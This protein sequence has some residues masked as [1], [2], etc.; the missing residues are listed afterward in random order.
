MP[1]LDEDLE[2]RESADLAAVLHKAPDRANTELAAM[3][4]EVLRRRDPVEIVGN[5]ILW[6]SRA[7]IAGAV[8]EC[9]RMILDHVPRMHHAQMTAMLDT[10]E[11]HSRGD[12][13]LVDVWDARSAARI[14]VVDSVT[15]AFLNAAEAAGD[16]VLGF[17]DEALNSAGTALMGVIE[18]G[19]EVMRDQIVEIMRRRIPCPTVLAFH[20]AHAARYA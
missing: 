12:A 10:I 17:D 8:G 7:V 1:T 2:T 11:H 14:H 4:H 20:D 18:S 9:V 6:C 16:N 19:G 3:W 13:S 15:E 5:A